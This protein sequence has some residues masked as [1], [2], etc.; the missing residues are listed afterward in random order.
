MQQ[1]SCYSAHR[2]ISLFACNLLLLAGCRGSRPYSCVPVSGKVTYEDGSLIPADQI[3]LIFLSL[4]KPIDLKTT[5]KNGLADAKGRSGEF[6]FATT[7]A[8]RDGII[9]GQHKVVV[10]CIRGGQ[11]M[12]DL[13]P[14]EYG[15]AAKTPLTVR[16]G[17]SPFA[18]TVP[19]PG[20]RKRT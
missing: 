4:A 7:F 9:V 15:D 10:Q 5:P 19:K 14:A 1:S 12:R 2:A 13:V 8:F 11:L 18:L 3:H 6:E 20:T 17:E 16:S